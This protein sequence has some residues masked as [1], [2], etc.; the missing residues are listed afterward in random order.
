MTRTKPS[1]RPAVA[2]DHPRSKAREL[3]LASLLLLAALKA[4]ALNFKDV[5]VAAGFTPDFNADIPAGGIAVADFNRDGWPDIFVT[6]YSRPNRVFFNQGDGSFVEDP[7]INQQLAGSQC[8]VTAA[9]DF[10]ND[11]WSDLYVGCRGDANHLFRNLQG[12]GFADV[13][14]PELQH[15][16]ANALQQRTDAVAWGDLDG[17]GLADLLQRRLR[18]RPSLEGPG[19]PAAA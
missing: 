8:S 14:P 2:L 9:A 5:S 6:G 4:H 19:V 18:S 7:A 17:N 11:G 13:T 3:A 16:P 10:D 12:E 1:H 15:D